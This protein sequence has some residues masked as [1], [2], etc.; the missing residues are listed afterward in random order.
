M[1]S[2]G[3]AVDLA[4]LRGLPEAIL[5]DRRH[6]VQVGGFRVELLGFSHPRHAPPHDSQVW[7]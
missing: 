3:G 7:W 5:Q 1:L 6:S 4:Q 2:Q